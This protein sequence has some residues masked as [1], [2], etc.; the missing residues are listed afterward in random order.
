M[1]GTPGDGSGVRQ[2]WGGTDER[3]D[4]EGVAGHTGAERLARP[5]PVRAGAGQ[6]MVE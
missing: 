6:A 3:G 2:G 4:H 5:R 1:F